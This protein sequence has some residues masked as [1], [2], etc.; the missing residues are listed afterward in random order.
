MANAVLKIT[1]I[2]GKQVYEVPI[3]ANQKRSNQNLE[4]DLPAGSYLYYLEN[5]AEQTLAKKLIIL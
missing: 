1:D 4:I 5:N 3:K 2:Q